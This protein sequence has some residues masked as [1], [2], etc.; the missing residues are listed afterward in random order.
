MLVFY[1]EWKSDASFCCQ[2]AA[3]VP[4]MFSNF[5]LVKNHKIAKYSTTTNAREKIST[6][7][8]PLEFLNFFMYIWLTLK[9]IKFYLIKLATD[10]YWQ[11]SYLKGER[12][13]LITILKHAVHWRIELR[14]Y[15][16]TKLQKHFENLAKLSKKSKEVIFKF[17]IFFILKNYHRSV[18]F[19][20]RS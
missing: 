14:Y 8:E 5:Y 19:V 13:S 7:L 12:Y 17:N 18:T 1:N 11:T 4:D 16:V 10:F 15:Q 9:A 20:V 2:V 3:W 6:D